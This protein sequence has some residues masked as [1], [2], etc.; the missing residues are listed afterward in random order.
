MEMY[1]DSSDWVMTP[2][3]FGMSTFA[4][5]GIMSTKPYICGSNYIL[6]MS[7]YKK[8]DWCDVVDGLYWK[9]I[10][11]NKS[12]LSKNPRLSIMTRALEKIDKNRKKTIYKLA[13]E[14]MSRNSEQ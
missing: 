5:G 4:D 14:F 1:I 6:K 8:G 10:E 7:N 9:F 13:E 12:F 3:V 11:K 2:N